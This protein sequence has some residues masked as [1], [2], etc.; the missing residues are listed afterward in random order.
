MSTLG[1]IEAQENASFP[2]LLLY[3]YRCFKNTSDILRTLLSIMSSRPLD[4][5]S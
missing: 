1:F 2:S 5:K 4:K 3:Y